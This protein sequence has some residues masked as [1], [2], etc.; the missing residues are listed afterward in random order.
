MAKLDGFQFTPVQ[1][2][3]SPEVQSGYEPGLSYRVDPGNEKLSTLV[4]GWLAEGK[5][6]PFF[7]TIL[8]LGG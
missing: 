5:V 4:E 2:F 6:V 8:V 3:W 1:S 7:G